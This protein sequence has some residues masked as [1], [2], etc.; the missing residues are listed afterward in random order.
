MEQGVLKVIN[1]QAWQLGLVLSLLIPGSGCVF[2][3]SA[4]MGDVDS[5]VVLEGERF[6][7]R[8]SEQGFNLQEGAM[9]VEAF[10]DAANHMIY[11]G[12]YNI[13]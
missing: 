4:Q 10:A 11:T 2:L 12:A 9:L 7:I 8:I 1:R 5:K 3:H 6:E 13:I